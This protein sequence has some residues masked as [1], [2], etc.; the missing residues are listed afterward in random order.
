MAKS[1][2]P[3][4]STTQLHIVYLD[5]DQLRPDP[6]NPRTHSRKQIRQIA[7]SIEI[8]GFNVPVLIN[9]ERQVIAGHGRLLA[10]PLLGMTRVPT[11]SLE[12]LSEAQARAFMIAD[13]KLTENGGWDDGRL[14]QHFKTLAEVDLDFSLETTGFE[15]AEIDVMIEGLDEAVEGDED[16]ADALPEADA[17]VRVSQPGDLWLL[18]RHRV[19]CG[20]ALQQ[21]SYDRLLSGRRG[22]AVFTDPPYNL[23]IDHYVTNFGKIKHSEFAMASGEMTPAEFNQFL[24]RIFRHLAANSSNGSLHFVCIDWRHLPELL[25]A[26]AEVYSEFKNLCVWVKN[27]AGQG[28]LYRSQHELVAVFKN[29]KD[30]HRN[31]ILL[32]QYGRYRTNVWQYSRVNSLGSESEEGD[33]ALLHPTIKPASMV[34]DAILDCTARNE[35]V[36]DAFLGSGT[37]VIAAERTGRV[38]YGLELDPVYVDTIVRRWQRF[39]GRSAVHGKSGK[40]FRELEEEVTHAQEK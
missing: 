38:C 32:G 2:L 34:A 6:A 29:G 26:G 22:S 20:D 23:K 1:K 8:F 4:A 19:Y 10:C 27:V 21:E 39:T 30:S 16:P 9:A 35:I 12:H 24:T 40:P 14:A 17:G 15:M 11:L 36:L 18:D 13:N 33:L 31:N 3:K 5:V 25:A 28:S 37:T 7:R